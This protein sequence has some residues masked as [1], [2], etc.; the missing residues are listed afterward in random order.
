MNECGTFDPTEPG[1]GVVP[2]D[3]SDPEI[4]AACTALC[5]ALATVPECRTDPATCLDDCRLRSCPICPGTLAPLV[6]C[7]TENFDA[8]ACRCGP[9]GASCPIPAPCGDLEDQTGFCGG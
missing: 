3:P 5:E 7:E 1:D 6:T 8:A 9:Q 2:Q 4:I